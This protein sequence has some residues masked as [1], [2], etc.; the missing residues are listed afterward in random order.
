[1]DSTDAGSCVSLQ[2]E[3]CKRFAGLGQIDRSSIAAGDRKRT[4]SLEFDC[5]C[6][7]AVLVGEDCHG[8]YNFLFRAEHPGQR[9]LDHHGF[10]HQH[11]L[12]G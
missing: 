1:M 10:G 6:T 2:G 12:V 11:A 7:D 4:V 8:E 9:S 3:V 5:H